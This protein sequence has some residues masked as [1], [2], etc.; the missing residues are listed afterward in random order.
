MLQGLHVYDRAATDPGP[1]R[2][3]I[4]VAMAAILTGGDA[5]P[6]VSG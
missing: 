5:A 6:Q 4:E 1:A 3:A 2:D